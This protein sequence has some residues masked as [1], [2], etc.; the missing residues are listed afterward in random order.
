MLLC[1]PVAPQTLCLD[2][3]GQPHQRF[4][5]AHAHLNFLLQYFDDWLQDRER[6]LVP[7]HGHEHTHQVDGSL[8]I[9]LRPKGGR[10]I[11]EVKRLV[12]LYG[13]DLQPDMNRYFTTSRLRP[14]NA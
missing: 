3:L 2:V 14:V 13:V 4:R 8:Q 1:G 11:L 5:M 9:A 10:R 6:F 7:P 12:E